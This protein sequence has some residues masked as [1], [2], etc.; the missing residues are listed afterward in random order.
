MKKKLLLIVSMCLC[1]LGMTACTKTDPTT[2][3]Y[4][5]YSYS[6]LQKSAQDTIVAL[7][8]MSDEDKTKYLT[9]DNKIVVSL[10]QKWNEETK[11]IGEYVGCNAGDF[12]IT[13]SNDTLTTKQIVQFKERPLT[14]SFVYKYSSMELTDV[15]VGQI[16]ETANMSINIWIIIGIAAIALSIIILIVFGIRSAVHSKEEDEPSDLLADV[17]DNQVVN[18]IAQREQADLELT[19]V[20][21]AAISAATGTP[22]DGFVVRSIKRRK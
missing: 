10:I 1:I 11:G 17:K 13:K 16:K 5:G 3:V 9:G 12:S 20:I 18:Q 6:D 7:A 14:V 2:A 21:A 22:T 19:A 8:K 4:N 15:T